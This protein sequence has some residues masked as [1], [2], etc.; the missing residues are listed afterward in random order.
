MKL[1]QELKLQAWLDGEASPD[2]AREVEQL[3]ANDAHFAALAGELRM[4]KGI[5]A[6]SEPE[7]VKLPESREFYF[8]KI[9]REIERLERQPAPA[10]RSVW[11]SAWMRILAP[12]TGVAAL[13][14]ILSLPDRSNT[15]VDETENT[16]KESTVI[17][18][19][20]T[21]EKMDV[22]WIHSDVDPMPDVS[23]PD[24]STKPDRDDNN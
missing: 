4:S 9:S 24:L 15:G 16:I 3:L 7:A 20:S 19:H 23:S 8:S 6:G 10:A 14:L 18:F 1:E 21:T 13:T 12:V 22:I 11:A 17:Q 5:L 2:E